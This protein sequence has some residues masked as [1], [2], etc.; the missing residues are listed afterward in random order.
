MDGQAAGKKGQSL[1][2]RKA[3][4]SVTRKEKCDGYIAC[5]K[6][7]REGGRERRTEF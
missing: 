1:R 7:E 2:Y 3:G 4:T 6:K 5:K